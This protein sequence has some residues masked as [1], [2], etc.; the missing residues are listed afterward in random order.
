MT[1]N[2]PAA[3]PSLTDVI[4][5]ALTSRLLET[6]IHLPGTVDSYENGKAGVQINIKKKYEDGTTS[7]TPVIT[8]VPVLLPRSDG[9]EAYL[10]LPIKRGDTGLLAFSQRSMDEWLIEGGNKAPKSVRMNDKSDAI[11]I[12]GL[13]PFNNTVSENNDNVVLKNGN[14][15]IELYPNGKIKIE[16]A[17]QDFLSLMNDTLSSLISAKVITGI[18]PMPFLATTVAEFTLIQQKL[19]TLIP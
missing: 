14:M 18:G 12:P 4:R 2:N 6:Y 13:Y 5:G 1:E 3:D 19:S 8:D 17:T 9:G 16:G 11:F 10:Q 7:L 15:S